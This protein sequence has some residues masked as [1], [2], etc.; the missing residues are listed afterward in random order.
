MNYAFTFQQSNNNNKFRLYKFE[1]ENMKLSFNGMTFLPAYFHLL[2]FIFVIA[3]CVFFECS[4][5]AG[6]VRSVD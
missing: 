6:V 5:I 1:I 2:N 4:I 3:L